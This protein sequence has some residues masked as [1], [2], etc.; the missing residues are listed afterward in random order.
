LVVKTNQGNPVTKAVFSF[1]SWL[2]LD[3]MLNY[4]LKE[5]GIVMHEE[6]RKKI[7]QMVYDSRDGH[8]PS[9]FSIIDMVAILYEDFLKFNANDPQWEG[10]DYFFLSKGHGCLGLYVVLNK[11]GFISDE[12]L[13][14][15]CTSGG[16]LGEHPDSTLVAGVEACTGSLGHGLPIAVGMALGLK[17]RT[18]SNNVYVLIGDG[19]CHEGTIWEAAHV[20]RNLQL[21]NLCVIV[22]WNKSGAQLM[23]MDDLPA[24]W[25][26][27]GWNTIV[28]DGHSKQEIMAALGQ[29]KTSKT[30]RPMAIIANTVKGKGVAMLEGHGR[31][32]HRIPTEEELHQIMEAL[33]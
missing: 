5:D 12:E 16:I 2:F 33:S 21:G 7:V 20:A 6:F 24:K 9:A 31:W 17:I 8:I 4:P 1:C 25:E 23:P 11:H 13:K 26:A 3:L 30:D 19:E 14:G 27:F 32:H 15:F 18:K 28:I 22:D 10:R 29:A